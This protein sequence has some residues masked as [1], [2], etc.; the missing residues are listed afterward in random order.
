MPELWANDLFAFGAK[1]WKRILPLT[2]SAP[3][4]LDLVWSSCLERVGGRDM[5][6]LA[7]RAWRI[8]IDGIR[9]KDV[10]TVVA[11]LCSEPLPLLQTAVLDNSSNNRGEQPTNARMPE[12]PHLRSLTLTDM[13]LAPPRRGALHVFKLDLSGLDDKRKPSIDAALHS[14]E[15][16]ANLR[17]LELR[18]CFPDIRSESGPPPRRYTF[19]A[20]TSLSFSHNGE[21]PSTAMRFLDHLWLPALQHAKIA[22]PRTRNVDSVLAMLRR[23]IRLWLEPHTGPGLNNVSKSTTSSRQSINVKV[24]KSFHVQLGKQLV[25]LSKE[26]GVHITTR[27][28]SSFLS[29]PVVFVVERG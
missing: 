27:V 25:E 16:N 5:L 26:T 22:A 17:A 10:R 12:H 13:Y 28:D 19:S 4:N 1:R 14:L 8:N 23:I 2:K 9:D 24:P 18:E 15:E 11:L 6:S 3:L 29:G 20:L 7:P 21:T